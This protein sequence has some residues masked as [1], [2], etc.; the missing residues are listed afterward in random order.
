MSPARIGTVLERR[1]V[2]RMSIQP[3]IVSAMR[4]ARRLAGER[5]LVSESGLQGSASGGSSGFS[6]GQIST[7]PGLTDAHGAMSRRRPP[8]VS[9]G[10][11]RASAN[12]PIDRRENGRDGS[13]RH[14]Q[15]D[16]LP[17]EAG[18]ARER[19]EALAC[20]REHLRVGALERIDRLLFVADGED[21]ASNAVA[22]SGTCKKFL[23]QG[24]DDL[25]LLG[26]RVLR[27]VDENVIEA[28]VEL[29]EHPLRFAAFAFEQRLRLQDQVVEIE[30][31]CD[32]SRLR[33]AL[34]DN[35][36][37]RVERHG[38][39]NQR[40]SF[41]LFRQGEE[42]LLRALAAFVQPRPRRGECLGHQAAARRV[43]AIDE[44]V[45][46]QDV[47][48]ALRI[49]LLFRGRQRCGVL[50]V[51]H[52]ACRKMRANLL[53]LVFRKNVGTF[54]MNVGQR[55]ADANAEIL[56]E[57]LIHRREVLQRRRRLRAGLR[58]R[59]SGVLRRRC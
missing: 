9:P 1:D 5:S 12:T 3:W 43:A 7:K 2:R 24:F 8:A 38:G 48:A 29:V 55:H 45:V 23:G 51:G 41:Q 57:I 40:Q 27:F 50:L 13:K 36:G 59:A 32:A 58:H 46:A 31:A 4:S 39:F 10:V 54:L 49:D 53:Q 11:F 35:A 44:E 15:F 26:A 14:R 37:E 52:G 22:A 47:E 17:G 28:A 20:V 21:R 34:Q 25:P 33:V 30:R 19:C 6:V 56:P 18:V 16:R 42:F